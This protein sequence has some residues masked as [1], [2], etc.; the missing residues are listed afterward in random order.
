M[1]EIITKGDK[2]F[3]AQYNAKGEYLQ[4]NNFDKYNGVSYIRKDGDV[5]ISDFDDTL[6]ACTNLS[7]V[8]IPLKIV[9]II[10]RKKIDIDNNFSED[11][12][13]QTIIKSLV[14]KSTDFKLSLS[15]RSAKLLVTGYS[16]DSIKILSEEYSGLSKKD[17]NYKFVYI[18]L[19]VEINAVVSNECLVQDCYSYGYCACK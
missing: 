5:S 17:I 18:S 7:N 16:T 9:A 8:T 3:P 11:I 6:R 2:S 10:P 14:T 15:A 19:D 4:I 12:V 13:A 1:C